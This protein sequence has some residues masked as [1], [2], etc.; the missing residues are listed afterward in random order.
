MAAGKRLICDSEALVDGG[1]GV[2][3]TVER[4]GREEPAFAVRFRGTVYGYLNRC[5]HTPI[6]LDWQAGEFFDLERRW[7][8]CATHGAIYHP[9][10]GECVT[11]RCA[12]R[13]L[14][15]LKLTEDEGQV[16]V[17]ETE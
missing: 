5:G 14:V 1:V 16:Y 17:V 6:E 9:A 11:G 10:T 12:G 4:Y 2:R 3:F 7:I 13:G 15:A 8:M